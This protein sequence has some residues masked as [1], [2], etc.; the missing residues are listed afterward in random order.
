MD[1]Q[2]TNLAKKIAVCHIFDSEIKLKNLSDLKDRF[3]RFDS[4]DISNVELND[5]DINLFLLEIIQIDNRYLK[6]LEDI[7][8]RY[9]NSYVYLFTP[10]ENQC[11]IFKL[12]NKFNIKAVLSYHIDDNFI[13]IVS[14]KIALD[15][16]NR[17]LLYFGEQI[18]KVFPVLIFQDCRLVFVNS[19]AKDFFGLKDIG[20]IE[21]IIRKNNKL[22]NLIL[23]K[24]T[25]NTK[26]TLKYG[27]KEMFEQ[28]CSI[29]YQKENDRTVLSILSNEEILYHEIIKLIQNKFVFLEKLKD[30]MVQ[31]DFYSSIYLT[32]IS[33]NNGDQ[34]EESCSKIEYYNFL[35]NFIIEINRLK[36]SS[37]KVIE[38]NPKM[39]ILVYKGVN[40]ENMKRNMA[41]LHSSIVEKQKFSRF[42]PVITTSFFCIDKKDLNDII[43]FIEKIDKKSLTH[44]EIMQEQYYEYKYFD[45]RLEES[46]QIKQMLRNCL[47]NNTHIKL[48]NIYKGLCVTTESKVLK[49]KKGFFYIQAEKLQIIAMQREGHIIIQS[50]IFPCNILAT[51]RVF[52]INKEYIVVQN[53]KFLE[54]SANSRLYTRVQPSFRTLIVM[55]KDKYINYGEILD[56]SINSISIKTKQYIDYSMIGN[57]VSLS[58]KL[59]DSDNENGYSSVNTIAKIKSIEFIQDYTKVMLLFEQEDVANKYILKY[60]Y[61]RQKELIMELKKTVQLKSSRKKYV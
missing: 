42:S 52:N 47:N 12:F 3:E 29:V 40:F 60:V 33:I 9:A 13:D 58:F 8:N 7:K 28:L 43:E 1:K 48:L 61:Y 55:K 44:D 5:E 59:F 20:S 36:N 11:D 23:Q 6:L 22:Y 46:E 41:L 30:K 21:K 51:V 34:I 15:I 17:N 2:E 4:F 45:D 16:K 19:S 54:T 57:D 18:N 35:K 24:I 37:D 25:L 14:H 39:Y 56:I 31:E 27:D 53:L 32:C 38:W 49:Y 10:L 26:L 50:P